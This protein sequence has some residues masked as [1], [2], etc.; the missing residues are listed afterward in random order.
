MPRSLKGFG[1]EVSE[2]PVPP[3]PDWVY[4][5]KITL[6]DVQPPAWRRIRTPD[7]TLER[8]NETIQ[9]AMGWKGD[10]LWV[11]VV[12]KK[13]YTDEESAYDLEM[14][15]ASRSTLAS[16]AP[17]EGAKFRYT[18]DFGEDWHHEV[19]VEKIL[20]GE[21]TVGPSCLDGARA[22][23]PEDVGGVGGYEEFL[24]VV[25]DPDHERLDEWSEWDGWDPNFDP[26]AFDLAEAN[27]RLALLW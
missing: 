13:E 6:E 18:Y 21:S 15:E 20:T 1:V 3:K 24:R 12:G 14:Q 19:L 10:H 5:L 26:A 17:K 22:C 27:S 8:L 7:C 16:V 11:F 23:P 4:E 2:S 25:N 9:A